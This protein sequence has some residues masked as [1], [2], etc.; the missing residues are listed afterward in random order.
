MATYR[1]SNWPVWE[2]LC[3]TEMTKVVDIAEKFVFQL[4]VLYHWHGTVLHGGR[5]E[6]EAKEGGVRR[7]GGE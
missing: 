7:E 6:R 1:L 3:I 2:A 4:R 5:A